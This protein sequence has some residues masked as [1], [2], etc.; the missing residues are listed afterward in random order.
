MSLSVDEIAASPV[1]AEALRSF[2]SKMRLQFDESPRLARM[3]ASH[4][5]WLLSQS[6]F[7]LHLE[8]D[9]SKPG[10][11]LTT[12]NLRE[13]IT[14]N[15]A[16][17]RNTVLNYLDQL[18][19]YRFV[20]LAGDSNRRPRRYEATEVSH[21]AMFRW[22]V[23][24][25]AVLD[26]IDGG[27][28][29]ERIRQA[30]D[31]FRQLQPQIAHRAAYDQRWVNPPERVALFLWTEAGGLV[32]DELI[33][34]ATEIVPGV[35]GYDL[36][37]LEARVLAEHFMISRT[38]LQRLLRRSVEIGGLSVYGP[39]KNHY[40]LAKDFLTEYR[41]WQ[42]VKFA[43]VDEA[44]EAVCGPALTQKPVISRTAEI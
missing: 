26:A 6:A 3:L 34:R 23:A 20:R 43:L 25:L 18:L 38:H 22:V 39:Q 31:L 35:D 15:N 12:T 14:V 7:A 28:R 27:R 10:S 11:G 9:P 41:Y 30:P 17:S 42:A 2:A 5:R 16:A 1:F 36:G 4:Q 40:I 29:E 24:N 33:R 8:Y 19:S 21:D 13:I 32:M 37:K 44:Y